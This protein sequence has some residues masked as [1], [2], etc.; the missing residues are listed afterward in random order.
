MPGRALH[1]AASLSCTVTESGTRKALWLALSARMCAVDAQIQQRGPTSCVWARAMCVAVRAMRMQGG[2]HTTTARGK[3]LQG[4]PN[5]LGT[6]PASCANALQV[7]SRPFTL[8]AIRCSP[9][10]VCHDCPTVLCCPFSRPTALPS[11]MASYTYTCKL[12]RPYGQVDTRM[13]SSIL[14]AFASGMQFGH[15]APRL[16][17][18][19]RVRGHGTRAQHP[20]GHS[21]TL[22][23]CQVRRKP[24]RTV[25]Y[26]AE[27]ASSG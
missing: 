8:G 1:T 3:E 18:A 26:W 2:G 13:H 9:L 5:R 7:M 25:C 24:Y 10:D 6:N 15:P 21:Y 19:H 17:L 27:A 12:T 14:A 22:Q 4:I 20:L 11:D 23:L 16:A